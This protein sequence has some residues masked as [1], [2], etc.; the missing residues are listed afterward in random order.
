MKPENHRLGELPA[1]LAEASWLSAAVLIPLSVDLQAG[2]IFTAPKTALT[3][4][5]GVCSALALS[6]EFIARPRI[7]KNFLYVAGVA[8]AFLAASFLSQFYAVDPTRAGDTEGVVSLGPAHL[9]CLISV[10][11]SVA[12]FLRTPQQLERLAGASLA[13]GFTVAAFALFEVYGFKA[14]GYAVVPGMQVVS[15]VGGPIF[16]AGY[17]LMLIPPAIWN[18]RRQMETC[19]GRFHGS[20]ATAAAVL[21]VLVS[22]F[23]ACDKRGPTLGLLAAICSGLILLAVVRRKYRL[24]VAA[25]AA[26]MLAMVLLAGL[27]VLKKAG[28]PLAKAPFVERLAAIVPVESDRNH[29]YR[30]MLWALLPE[31]IFAVEPVT[32]PSGVQD[33][34]HRIRPLVGYGPDN[35]QAVLPSRYIFLQAWPSEVMEVSSHSQ[36]WDLLINLG[37]AGVAAFFA[38]FFIVWYQGL[39]SM[40]ARPPPMK[41]AATI[42]AFFGVAAGFAA[43][44]VLPKA[45]VGVATQA[46]FLAGLLCLCL[47][48]HRDGVA[49]AS[50]SPADK[51]LVMAL[52]A[53]L[54]GHWI[55]LA[56]IFP[57]AENS[58]LFWVFAGALCGLRQ[59]HETHAENDAHGQPDQH[60]WVVAIGAVLLVSVIHARANLGPFLAGQMQL[61]GI[62]GTGPA[63]LIVVALALLGAWA[64]CSVGATSPKTL[65]AAVENMVCAKIICS[66][67]LYLGAVL[68]FAKITAR[69]A[70]EPEQPWLADFWALH[71][72]VLLLAGI[73]WFVKS[74]CAQPTKASFGMKAVAGILFCLSGL[75]MWIGPMRNLR[76]SISAG[77]AGSL[78][79]S[80][81]WMERS[82]SLRPELMRNY[83]RLANR[84]MVEGFV[85]GQDDET[86]AAALDKAEKI[87]RKGLQVSSFNLLSSKLGRLLLWRA[88]QEQREAK[89]AKLA[90]AAQQALRQAVLFAP[91]NEPAWL[92]SSL[93]EGLVLQNP[94]AAAENMKR[95][96]KVTSGAEAWQNVV[97]EQWGAYYAGLAL[98]APTETLRKSYARH[99]QPFLLLHL[100]ET[101]KALRDDAPEPADE[102]KVK[103]L[104]LARSRSMQRLRDVQQI[105][106]GKPD[107]QMPGRNSK[108]TGMKR[109]ARPD[110]DSD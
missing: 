107:E 50:N 31:F 34:H 45:F 30:T 67:L 55:D 16:L 71:L 38:L 36:F 12:Y 42:A 24:I 61:A 35:L 74:G 32:L 20:T 11:L 78:P 26:A 106:D 99:A 46:G 102:I 63:P 100:A 18:L 108:A 43:A 90:L 60:R 1:R 98:S 8:L 68:W 57:T 88:A 97:E 95:A 89:R 23:L 52:L 6:L 84:L 91:Q 56:F 103:E 85:T 105:L 109:P 2:Q 101:E 73:V 28:A 92:D 13:A 80:T 75:L 54:A 29:D 65:P 86:K 77:L 53:S 5:L 104:L 82:I 94:A 19:G 44:T 40:G 22:A 87:L 79:D 39:L 51:L 9:A 76:S 21:L 15:F 66:G 14:P 110:P 70:P 48:P 83:Y 4:I 10:F 93:L 72:P 41:W 49:S 81:S 17:L 37:A 58:I 25:L 3:Q 7:D 69:F 96:D 62:F 64:A 27:A 47:R 59:G 33:P